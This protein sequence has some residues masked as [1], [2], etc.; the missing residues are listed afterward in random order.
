MSERIAIF[1]AG[2]SG[3]GAL[4]LAEGL[5]QA[6]VVFDE[7]AGGT[8]RS[9]SASDIADFDCF[10]FSPGFAAEHPWRELAAGSGKPVMGELAY[11]AI[12]WKG[13]L[14]GITGT[15]G[16]TTITRL[17]HEAYREMGLKA[18]ACGNIG[19]PLS[20]AVLDPENEGTGVAVVE[21]S[22]FQAEL[23]AGLRLDALLWTTFAEDHLDRYVTMAAYFDAKAAL[24]DCLAP[25]AI[26]V[27]GK[28]IVPSMKNYGRSPAGAL[29]ANADGGVPPEGPFARPPQRQNFE[30]AATYW[31][32]AGYPMEPLFAVAER[33]ELS[34]HR[35]QLVRECG[36]IRFWND[37][38]ATNFEAA[39]AAVASLPRPIVWIGGGQAKGGDVA[40]FAREISARVDAA[41]LYGAVGAEV[42]GAMRLPSDR[43]RR[44]VSF[45]KAV[46]AA[47]AMAEALPGAQVILSPGFASFDQFTSYEERGKSFVSIVLGL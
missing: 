8:R 1:G 34:A 19:R 24:L 33:F 13:T 7:S 14:I 31:R 43:L 41:V 15:N 39:L 17:L 3:Q 10:V 30:V 12:H 45:A 16:K 46:E 29:I 38:K 28:G 20:E 47:I 36:G 40:G 4:K 26:L 6:A 32:A 2:R 18:V 44:V 27:L 35:C 5:G 22:S 37:S 11:A 21:I 23:A 42:A 9:F 25:G